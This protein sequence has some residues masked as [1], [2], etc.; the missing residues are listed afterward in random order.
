MQQEQQ[1]PLE[2]GSTGMNAAHIH[3]EKEQL[4]MNLTESKRLK[5]GSQL[6]ID[7]HIA[8]LEIHGSVSMHGANPDNTDEHE[9]DPAKIN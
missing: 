7:Q 6:T 4:R 1:V 3:S 2:D 5:N 8:Q 9:P